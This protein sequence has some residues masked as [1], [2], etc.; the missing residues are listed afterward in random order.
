[1]TPSVILWQY[2]G[3]TSAILRQYFGF[4][5]PNL[6]LDRY[7]T[8]NYL[9]VNYVNSKRSVLGEVY[10]RRYNSVDSSLWLINATK[11]PKIP[12]IGIFS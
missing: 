1:M 12:Y 11:P 2:F 10:S 8:T 9:L 7:L 6:L 5:N 4:R 3:N